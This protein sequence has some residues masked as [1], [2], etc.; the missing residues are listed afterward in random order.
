VPF[1]GHLLDAAAP[2]ADQRKLG[3]DEEGVQRDEDGNGR[4]A[5]RNV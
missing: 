4:Q 1:F 3:R 2:E 5:Y